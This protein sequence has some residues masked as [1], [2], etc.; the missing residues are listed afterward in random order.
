MYVP[1][2]FTYARAHGAGNPNAPIVTFGGAFIV[3]AYVSLCIEMTTLATVNTTAGAFDWKAGQ[4]GG[5][6]VRFLKVPLLFTVDASMSQRVTFPPTNTV[7][8]KVTRCDM[9]ASTV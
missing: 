8:G 9:L 1:Y 2:G 5:I 6:K 7:G 3:H 4:R